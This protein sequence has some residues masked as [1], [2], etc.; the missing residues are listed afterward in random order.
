MKLHA[1][2]NL[3]SGHGRCYSAAPDLLEPDDMGYVSIRG[4][5]IDVPADQED[6]AQRA[7]S[8]CP[9]RAIT[10]IED[11]RGAAGAETGEA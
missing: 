10:I 4:T 11:S 7:A 9:E 1:D 6:A 8:W 5:T 2:E 3:C